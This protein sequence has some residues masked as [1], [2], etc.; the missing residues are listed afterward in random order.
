MPM[1]TFQVTNKRIEKNLKVGK[2]KNNKEF[3]AEATIYTLVEMPFQ[4]LMQIRPIYDNSV[5][6]YSEVDIPQKFEKFFE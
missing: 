6:W 4:N 3:K 5:V 1:F 2:I